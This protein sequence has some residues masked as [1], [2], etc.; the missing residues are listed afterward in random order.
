MF[1]IGYQE[2][3]EHGSISV[4]Y[5]SNIKEENYAFPH[6]SHQRWNTKLAGL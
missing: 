1:N 4:T 2:K 5:A 6:L 3:M